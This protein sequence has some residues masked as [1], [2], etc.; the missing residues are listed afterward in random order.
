MI[1][2]D[3]PK[4]NI[5]VKDTSYDDPSTTYANDILSFDTAAVLDDCIPLCYNIFCDTV[6][7]CDHSVSGFF[8]KYHP[9]IF[10]KRNWKRLSILTNQKLSVIFQ[11]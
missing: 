7:G 5:S 4:S 9:C 6:I 1:V 11:R 2:Q 10:L 8:Q 3:I